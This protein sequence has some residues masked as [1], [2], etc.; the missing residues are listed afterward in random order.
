MAGT[1]RRVLPRRRNRRIVLSVDSTLR[2]AS[3]D[4]RGLVPALV[5]DGRPLLALMAVGL[6][7]AGAFAF[8]LAAVGQF[9]PH[10]LAFLGLTAAELRSLAG[11]RIVSF[12]FHDR[13]AFGGTLVAV[14]IL[15]LWLITFPLREG[16]AWA[17]WTLVI[18][19]SIG[20]ASF[21]A[22]FV[23]GYLDAWHGVAT[24]ALLPA[25]TVGLAKARSNLQ[26]PRGPGALLVPDELTPLLSRAGVGRAMLLL[27][28]FG[29]LV[30]GMTILTLGSLVVFVPQDLEF[31]GLNRM[32]LDSLNSRLVPLIAH[33]RSGFGGGLATTGL[34]VMA[35]VWCGRPSRSLWEALLVAGTVGFAAALGV[36][37]PI[38]YHDLG[39]LSPA[40][41]GAATFAVGI[42][43][44]RPW[45]RR[46]RNR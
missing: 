45:M 11:G 38:G 32:A 24:L 27:T 18:S 42:L 40:F 4:E 2:T 26:E 20:F 16:R 46:A 28:A 14:G 12:M 13:V 5:G 41:L 7:V 34:I 30:A 39:H 8:F 25:F 21:L 3:R 37:L 31:I 44:T 6:I 23:Y 33:D 19:G 29:M 1:D 43:A 9:L 15:Y 35:C 36:H 22:Y 10:D 17:W